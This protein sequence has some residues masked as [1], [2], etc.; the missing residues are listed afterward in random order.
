MWEIEKQIV[1]DCSYELHSQALVVAVGLCSESLAPTPLGKS[2]GWSA[3][4]EMAVG[5]GYG[6]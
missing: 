6:V 4:Q 3:A 1:A 2:H 5:V